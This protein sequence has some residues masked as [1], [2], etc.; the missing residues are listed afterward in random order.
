MKYVF[1]AYKPESHEYCRGC[2][3]GTYPANFIS[4]SGLTQEELVKEWG[5]IQLVNKSL[6]IDEE[7]YSVQIWQDGMLVWDDIDGVG[8][9]GEFE[10]END[11]V[12]LAERMREIESAAYALGA[13]AKDERDRKLREAAEEL[14]I[15]QKEAAQEQRRKQ[16]E[17][18]KKEFGE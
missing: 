15:K 2:H 8:P 13:K 16:F 3:M 18:L 7:G 4:R 12:R 11:Y 14:K 6:D 5:E 17:A 10:D 1:V 9:Q